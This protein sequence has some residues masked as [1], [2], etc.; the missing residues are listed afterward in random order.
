[1]IVAFCFLLNK[2]LFTIKLPAKIKKN[3][4]KA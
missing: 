1:M 3:F 2:I 4:S